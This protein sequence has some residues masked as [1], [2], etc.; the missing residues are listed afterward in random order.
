[1]DGCLGTIASMSGTCYLPHNVFIVQLV[2]WCRSSVI[3]LPTKIESHCWQGGKKQPAW[4]DSHHSMDLSR[5]AKQRAWQCRTRQELGFWLQ[6][7]HYEKTRTARKIPTSPPVLISRNELQVKEREDI[8]HTGCNMNKDQI[9]EWW[10]L[11]HRTI[12]ND[13]KLCL[14][15]KIQRYR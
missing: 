13:Q 5:N 6:I 12:K 4:C 14:G 9:W 10:W 7:H 8:S 1:M 2:W 3:N 15:V 11:V